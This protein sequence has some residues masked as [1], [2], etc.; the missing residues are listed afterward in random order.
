MNWLKNYFR[1]GKLISSCIFFV[2]GKLIWNLKEKLEQHRK[3]CKSLILQCLK[4]SWT[5][6]DKYLCQIY[7]WNL[8]T[9]FFNQNTIHNLGQ[10]KSWFFN[11]VSSGVMLKTFWVIA[12]H[13]SVNITL[14]RAMEL[15]DVERSWACFL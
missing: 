13:N 4:R 8:W 3:L 2:Y 14:P 7:N 5:V 11:L 15:W 6:F 1:N 12:L 9:F 10:H